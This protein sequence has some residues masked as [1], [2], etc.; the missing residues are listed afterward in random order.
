LVGDFWLAGKPFFLLGG[1]ANSDFFALE[2]KA[3]L[4]S[5]RSA[6]ACAGLQRKRKKIGRR[7]GEVPCGGF[8][9]AFSISVAGIA[10]FRFVS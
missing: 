10:G 3:R 2:R 1:L 6:E 5:E 9:A 8:H 4:A 7:K